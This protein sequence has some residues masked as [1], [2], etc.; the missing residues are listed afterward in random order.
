M[1]FSRETW[2]GIVWTDPLGLM[3][4]RFADE[5]VGQKCFGVKNFPEHLAFSKVCLVRCFLVKAHDN[6]C[7]HHSEGN[8]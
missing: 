2:G 7:A 5:E 6:A 1:G 4:G 8:V 3:A